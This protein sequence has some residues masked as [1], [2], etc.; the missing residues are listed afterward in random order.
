MKATP[1]AD[2]NGSIAAMFA[3]SKIS[4]AKVGSTVGVKPKRARSPEP[5]G[6]VDRPPKV[7]RSDLQTS[8]SVVSSGQ[9]SYRDIALESMKLK[10]SPAN[11]APND[12]II[13]RIRE[14]VR[15]S[16]ES[17]LTDNKKTP[18]IRNSY[19]G[20]D[21]FYVFCSDEFCVN[22]L[23]GLENTVLPN[24]D[25][26]LLVLPY[27]QSIPCDAIKMVRVVVCL[28]TSIENAFI[29]KGFKNCN[30]NIN[31]DHWR[32]SGRKPRGKYNTVLFMRMDEES[33][34]LVKMN[35]MRVNWTLGPVAVELEKKRPM[36]GNRFNEATEASAHRTTTESQTDFGLPSSQEVLDNEY[37]PGTPGLV[38]VDGSDDA[39]ANNDN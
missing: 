2:P 11:K 27:K 14:F 35:E 8:S 13:K 1:N 4:N 38:N 16:I 26:K 20:S 30:P 36:G 3:A 28:N 25:I 39:E 24:T 6:S 37:Y 7:A 31:T 23:K 9:L 34:N 21:G 29:L 18:I 10:V 12:N 33:F 15:Y 32:I 5:A 19:I 17:L 22:W